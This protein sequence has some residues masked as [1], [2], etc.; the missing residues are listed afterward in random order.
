M[1]LTLLYQVVQRCFPRKDDQV[2]IEVCLLDQEIHI[3]IRGRGKVT[4]QGKR[5]V[6][7]GDLEQSRSFEVEV[8]IEVEVEV[9]QSIDINSF[10]TSRMERGLLHETTLVV[11]ATNVS[12]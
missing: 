7:G 12:R 9:G 8:E 6:H 4:C 11:K 3:A 10:G 1:N 5:C 2:D